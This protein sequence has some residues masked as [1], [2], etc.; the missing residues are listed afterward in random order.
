MSSLPWNWNFDNL[1]APKKEM[2][3]GDDDESELSD[4][5]SLGS[6]RDIDMDPFKSDLIFDASTDHKVECCSVQQLLPLEVRG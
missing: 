2:F 1:Q 4:E 3:D 6:S 5:M